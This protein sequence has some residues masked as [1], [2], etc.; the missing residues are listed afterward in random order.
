M[1]ILHSQR[2]LLKPQQEVVF[3]L[4]ADYTL[5]F[6]YHVTRA[7]FEFT[8]KMPAPFITQVSAWAQMLVNL[9]KRQVHVFC[10]TSHLGHMRWG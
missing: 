7:I 10:G 1:R 9:S 2:F 4:K 5:R 6:S 8:R 3:A